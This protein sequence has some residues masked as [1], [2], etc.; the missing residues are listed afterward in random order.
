MSRFYDFEAEDA[1]C[2]VHHMSEYAGQGRKCSG[3]F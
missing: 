3:S 1:R 2:Q